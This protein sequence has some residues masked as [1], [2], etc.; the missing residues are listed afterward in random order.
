MGVRDVSAAFIV[1]YE[2]YLPTIN[3]CE[4]NTPAMYIKNFKN[5]Y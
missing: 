1:S 4:N 3:K 5:I 2:V